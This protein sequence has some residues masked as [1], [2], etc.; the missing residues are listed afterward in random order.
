MLQ[1]L[2]DVNTFYQAVL[3]KNRREYMDVLGN[4]EL[5]CY[6]SGTGQP[7]THQLSLLPSVSLGLDSFPTDSLKYFPW[8]EVTIFGEKKRGVLTDVNDVSN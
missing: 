2:C 4:P 6:C 8:T 3:C 1:F 7:S 5:W